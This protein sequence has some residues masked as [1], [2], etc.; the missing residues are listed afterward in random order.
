MK[1]LLK[2]VPEQGVE[3]LSKLEGCWQ[4]VGKPVNQGQ[5]LLLQL[6]HEEPG[7]GEVEVFLMPDG[8]WVMFTQLNTGSDHAG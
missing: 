6:E 5:S 3:L 1:Y 4:F 2:V 7:L 8:T